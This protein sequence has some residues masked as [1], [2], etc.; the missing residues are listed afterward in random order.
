VIWSETF[1]SFVW[2]IIVYG[3]VMCD[4][5]LI[6]AKYP[7]YIASIQIHEFDEKNHASCMHIYLCG[8]LIK[9]I[10]KQCFNINQMSRDQA[11]GC[12]AWPNSYNMHGLNISSI[13]T[14]IDII[15]PQILFYK[16]LIINQLLHTWPWQMSQR[17]YC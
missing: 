10:V 11:K 13:S 12:N 9:W 14:S 4:H 17:F 8:C 2:I 5:T 16:G 6:V 1:R 15:V 3:N 7:A